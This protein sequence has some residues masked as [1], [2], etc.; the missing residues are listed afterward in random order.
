MVLKLIPSQCGHRFLFYVLAHLYHSHYSMLLALSMHSHLNT[1]FTH[2][3][4]FCYHFQI[5]PHK[6]VDVLNALYEALLNSARDSSSPQPSEASLSSEQ[7]EDISFRLR[8]DMESGNI[9]DISRL[10]VLARAERNIVLDKRRL[11]LLDG[12]WKSLTL[13]KS[14]LRHL[15]LVTKVRTPLSAPTKRIATHDTALGETPPQILWRC[16]SLLLKVWALPSASIKSRGLERVTQDPRDGGL[17]QEGFG[18]RE[19]EACTIP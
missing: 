14:I 1:I 4:A 2:F 19:T 6:E 10:H 16:L 5:L 7:S 17:G 13:L 3:M 9:Q 15:T 18:W 11:T 8:Q 12:L